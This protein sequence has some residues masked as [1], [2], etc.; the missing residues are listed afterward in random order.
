VLLAVSCLS[1]TKQD[2]HIIH[3]YV[4]A[5]FTIVQFSLSHCLK[6][7]ISNMGG[8]EDSSSHCLNTLASIQTSK[9]WPGV[10]NPRHSVTVQI[11]GV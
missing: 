10:L 3:M 8:E 7:H 5:L 1:S 4:T 9:K 6:L 2:T 11:H